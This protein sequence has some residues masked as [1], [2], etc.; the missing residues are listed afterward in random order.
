M[1][2]PDECEA[3]RIQV[4][5]RKDAQNARRAKAGRPPMHKPKAVK[6][7]P[8]ARAGLPLP[9]SGDV[10]DSA[11]SF[12]EWNACGYTVKKGQKF[13]CTDICGIPQFILSQVHKIN[14]SWERWRKKT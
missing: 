7:A 13:H 10:E 2:E 4:Q 1:K 9:E 5:A 14:P 11:M 3:L 12:E 6:R 8:A